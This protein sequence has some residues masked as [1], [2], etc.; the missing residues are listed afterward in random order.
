MTG[1]VIRFVATADAALSATR[2]LES[3]V[4][5]T[6]WTPLPG[7]RADVRPLRPLLLDVLRR[8][9]PLADA[10]RLVD[11]WAAASDVLSRLE[12][13]GFSM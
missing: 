11:G 12:I 4:L 13:D 7:E 5:D 1:R 9:D 6:A 2:G 3:I 10:R 8:H